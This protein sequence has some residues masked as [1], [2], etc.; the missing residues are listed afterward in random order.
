LN[1]LHSYRVGNCIVHPTE[2]RVVALLDWKLWTLGH[3]LGDLAYY[4]QAWRG[5]ATPGGSL[6][7]L[8]LEA[9]GARRRPT[10]APVA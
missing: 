8:D 6:L 1:L 2:P 3:P 5:E 7:G 10:G 4:C 9:L